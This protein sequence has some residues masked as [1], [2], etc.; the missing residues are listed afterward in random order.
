MCRSLP[1]LVLVVLGSLVLVGVGSGPAAAK[2]HPDHASATDPSGDAPAAIDLMSGTSP[3]WPSGRRVVGA[4]QG[5]LRNDVPRL[6]G[7]AADL[8]LGPDRGLLQ[9]TARRSAR[10]TSS[11]TRRRPSP[12]CASARKLKVTWKLRADKVT[13]KAPFSLL[14]ASAGAPPYEFHVFSRIGGVKNSPGDFLHAR[15]LDF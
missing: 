8:G 11:T 15:T 14:Q 2:P 9:S 7:L 3:H 12:T 1:A 4:G 6:R 5:A 10:S 13:V